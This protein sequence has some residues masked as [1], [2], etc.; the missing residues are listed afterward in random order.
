LHL[1]H[2]SVYEFKNDL[3]SHSHLSPVISGVMLVGHV[4]YAEMISASDIKTATASFI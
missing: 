3:K 1:T 4:S 2:R